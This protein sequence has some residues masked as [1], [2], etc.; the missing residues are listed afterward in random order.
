M[1]VCAQQRQVARKLLIRLF[2]SEGGSRGSA[3]TMK[4][5]ASVT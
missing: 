1:V 3:V 4:V 2:G 5:A